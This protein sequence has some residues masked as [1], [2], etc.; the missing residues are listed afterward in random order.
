M[1]YVDWP[2]RILYID[3]SELTEITAGEL[4]GLDTTD[5]WTLIH[6]I[7]DGE[8]GMANP[9]IMFHSLPYTLSGVSYA[10]AVE[11]INGYQIQFTG[12]SPP[13]DHYTV[14]LSGGN[15]NVAD[16]FIPNPVSVISNNSAGLATAA[17]GAEMW[18]QQLEGTYTAEQ[19][20]R[21]MVAALAGK[22][23]GADTGNIAIRD[24]ADTKDRITA[25][26][27]VEGNRT[28]VSLDGD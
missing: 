20:M 2:T 16:V 24:I 5:L 7:Q 17:A 6:D 3:Q 28:S 4:Y 13:N 9:D 26:T 21:I 14:V 23:S 1:A 15:N 18:A 8:D 25:T 10:R 12:P 22:L 11:I 27:T 19:M